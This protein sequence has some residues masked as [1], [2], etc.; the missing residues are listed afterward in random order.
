MRPI[1]PKTTGKKTQGGNFIWHGQA[2]EED[3]IYTSGLIS[4]AMRSPKPSPENSFEKLPPAPPPFDLIGEVAKESGV[5][6]GLAEEL[7]G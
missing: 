3:P 1:K 7:I 2:S 4:I 6:R 5:T